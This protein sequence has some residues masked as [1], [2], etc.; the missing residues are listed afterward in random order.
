VKKDIDYTVDERHSATLTEEGAL[1]VEKKL[2]LV[3]LSSLPT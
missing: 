1:R 3:K 2:G